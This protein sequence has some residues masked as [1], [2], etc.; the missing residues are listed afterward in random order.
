MKS[1]FPP[2]TF[3]FDPN[4]CAIRHRYR[5]AQ[6]T[7]AGSNFIEACCLR[8]ATSCPTH[9]TSAAVSTCPSRS[10]ATNPVRDGDHSVFA[11]AC[12]SATAWRWVS[13]TAGQLEDLRRNPEGNLR[14]IVE[15]HCGAST[16]HPAVMTHCLAVCDEYKGDGSVRKPKAKVG[17][18]LDVTKAAW[19]THW[20][21][22]I[23]ALSSTITE[24]AAAMR[25]P[26]RSDRRPLMSPDEYRLATC[27]VPG[28]C[29]AAGSQVC[30][31]IEAAVAHLI[32]FIRGRKGDKARSKGKILMA[33][34]SRAML[35]DHR[36]RTSSAWC[37]L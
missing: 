15:G 3:I 17:A 13:S 19:S 9:W 31:V 18:R 11:L 22:A 25:A 37:W 27:F 7:Y 28:R 10:V 23:T 14:D 2:K 8:S 26:N 21:R 12:D 5:R 6:T 30:R 24:E 20:S 36:P 34:G 29:F 16:A 35:H 4:S 1:A 33:H 32:P